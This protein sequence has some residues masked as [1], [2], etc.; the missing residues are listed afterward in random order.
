M[1]ITADQKNENFAPNVSNFSPEYLDEIEKKLENME[2]EVKHLDN[3]NRFS[4]IF[5]KNTLEYFLKKR[6]FKSYDEFIN[7]YKSQKGYDMETAIFVGNIEGLI[8]RLKSY[9][10][11]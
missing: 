8:N 10:N 3:L 7:K 1:I 5:G 9:L 4:D 2:L 11:G 6:K